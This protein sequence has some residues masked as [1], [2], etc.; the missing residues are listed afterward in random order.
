VW[1]FLSSKIKEL[2]YGRFLAQILEHPEGGPLRKIVV[3]N[4]GIL[5]YGDT[6]A[7]K[8]TWYTAVINTVHIMHSLCKFKGIEGWMDAKDIIIWFKIVGKNLEAYQRANTLSLELRLA[9][10]QAS[11]QLM[12]V[13]TKFLEHHPT[14]LDTL[15]SLVESVAN[16]GF[17]Q[18]H[19]LFTY[20]YHHIICNESIE[21]QK[22]IVLHSL[23]VYA[24][25]GASQKT[26]T[27]LLHNIV[28][29][30]V[31]M[32]VMRM[33]KEGSPKNSRLMD[34]TIIKSIHTKIWKVGFGDPNDDLGIDHT[35]LE[36][37]QLTATLVKYHY[38]VLQDVRMDIIKFGWAQ[39]R[40]E[41][42]IN[43]YAAYVVTG[44]CIAHYE[45]PANIVQRVYHS[46]LKTHQ[47]AGQALVT[48]ALELIATTF[49]NKCNADDPNSV[50]AVTPH[51]ILTEERQHVQQ[52]TTVFSFLVKHADFFYKYRDKFIILIVKSLRAIAPLPNC[53]GQSKKL[54]LRLM[55]LVWQWEQQRVKGKQMLTLEEQ[56][57]ENSGGQLIISSSL[58]VIN[59]SLADMFE[60]EIPDWARAEMVTYLLEFIVSLRR[61]SPPLPANAE[62]AT[63]SLPPSAE[64]INSMSMLHSLLH[65][66]YWGGVDTDLSKIIEILLAGDPTDNKWVDSMMNILQ[67][68]RVIADVKP[69][70]LK[71]M[72]LLEKLLEMSKKSDNSEICS[73][74]YDEADIIGLK[75]KSLRS[76][77][78]EC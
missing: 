75:M 18:I 33:S 41:D 25:K 71:S 17:R 30:I 52:M 11:E 78:I 60:Y 40:L 49:P 35:R 1:S 28:N 12:V 72:P 29:P 54:V 50:W 34:K 21:Y 63:A 13:F 20:I 47:D 26:K 67:V 62:V 23:E 32:D 31:A 42:V 57:F 45:T 66:Q 55:T 14:D 27:F 10:E 9:A 8:D 64:M 61:P 68:V 46:L 15:F 6:E 44:Y 51:R 7:V 77:G 4:I 39:T 69:H 56:N 36:A 19:P 58:S 2:K 48:Q 65:P 38:S 16:D 43:K 24:G 76:R 74:L 3:E 5:I 70:I 73:C 53:S 22:T 59:S 37:L